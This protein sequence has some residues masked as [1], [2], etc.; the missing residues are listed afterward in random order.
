MR[1][2]FII[3][4]NTVKK[5][6]SK[7]V[8]DVESA[9]EKAGVDWEIY[10]TD[11]P[12]AAEKYVREL[13]ETGASLRFYA[14]GGDGTIAEA[15]NGAFGFPNVEIAA[16]PSGTGND[17]VRNFAPA[18]AF[19]DVA[20]QINGRAAAFDLIKANDRFAVNTINIGFD[21]AVVDLVERRRGFPLFKGANAY[22]VAAFL[23]MFPMPKCEL[24]LEWDGRVEE[25]RLT[26][27]SIANG[28]YCGGGFMSNPTARL[29][30]G[31]IDVFR[32]DGKVGRIGFLKLFG[33]VLS[34]NSK[35][36]VQ[37]MDLRTTDVYTLVKEFIGLLQ[38][39]YKGQLDGVLEG[40]LKA[41]QGMVKVVEAG[42]NVE[43][44]RA[45][46]RSR[47]QRDLRH[48]S[49]RQRGNERLYA[50]HLRQRPGQGYEEEQRN[51]RGRAESL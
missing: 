49:S 18:E 13:A 22:T 30:D 43:P 48:L 20:R 41:L 35:A 26:L 6:R 11:A 46:H 7:L 39:D 28:R 32:A 36:A 5:L 16:I 8:S 23:E 9:C 38:N 37:A 27:C 34:E 51:D 2:V 47:K 10:Y 12:R 17:F 50:H 15:A 40:F 42:V 14:C 3:N 33:D 25:R 4:P 31:L 21:C 19:T 44:P 29:D 45:D 24:K 1:H